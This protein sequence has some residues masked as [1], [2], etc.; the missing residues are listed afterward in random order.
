MTG[1][2]NWT[3]VTDC[4]ECWESEKSAAKLY[5]MTLNELDPDLAERSFPISCE[6]GF[7]QD[8]KVPDLPNLKV[9]S[10]VDEKERCFYQNYSAS[11]SSESPI[12]TWYDND[13]KDAAFK[14]LVLSRGESG[15]VE[16]NP[17]DVG[18]RHLSLSRIPETLN[19]MCHFSI[20]MS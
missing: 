20:I 1:A 15:K 4:D 2:T 17:H 12:Q 6:L 8:L 13:M 19:Q 18:C 3:E 10:S 11:V 16:M 9:V 14:E 5:N 7:Q